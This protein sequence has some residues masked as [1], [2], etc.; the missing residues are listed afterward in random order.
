LYTPKTIDEGHC[1]GFKSVY[2]IFAR[3]KRDQAKASWP[4]CGNALPRPTAPGKSLPLEC[5]TTPKEITM[6]SLAIPSSATPAL[7]ALNIPPHSHGHGHKKG[8]EMDSLTD[9]SSSTAAQI[10]VSS[11]QNLFGSLLNTLE[12]VIG[13]QPNSQAQAAPTAP[14]GPGAASAQPS[15]GSK[16]NLTA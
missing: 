6:S 16:I 13:I 15:I 4:A 10:P 1:A 9:S 2:A 11:A 7:P 5:N 14:A 12:Q 3:F 8:S